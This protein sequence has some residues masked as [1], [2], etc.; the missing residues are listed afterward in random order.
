MIQVQSILFSYKPSPSP[1]MDLSQ[2]VVL[3][4]RSPHSQ[5]ISG[6]V[7]QKLK[8]KYLSKQTLYRKF[9]QHNHQTQIEE[10]SQPHGQKLT[11]EHMCP[12][13]I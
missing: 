9:N 5:V 8:L 11:F 2:P 4:S 1:S 10:I 12:G 3:V 7:I 13:I 6:T